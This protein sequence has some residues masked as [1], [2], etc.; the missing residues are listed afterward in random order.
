MAPQAM[1]KCI[2]KARQ[3]GIGMVSVK[4]GGHFGI[5]GYYAQKASDQG[6]IG[7]CFANSAPVMAAFKGRGTV[8]GNSPLSISFPKGADGRDNVMLDM[9]CSNVAYGKIQIADRKGEKLPPGWGVDEFGVETDDPQDL[10]SR[11]G[12]LL[13]FGGAKGYCLAVLLEM[14][15]AVLPGSNTG[16]DV[17]WV[18]TEGMKENLGYMFI[19]IDVNQIRPLKEVEKDIEYYTTKL[20]NTQPA[21]G[22]A[23]VFLPG[24]IEHKNVKK[25]IQEGFDLN[26]NVANDLLMLAKKYNRLSKDATI[27]DLFYKK[28][29]V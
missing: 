27:D 21:K 29:E 18:K 4:N 10:I 1:D 17:G 24:E 14:M 28:Q 9:A 15:A 20:K 12:S 2:E 6:L 5:A 23:E 3:A 8:L 11:P 16:V 7:I 22:S 26:L 19:A 13:P 25:R